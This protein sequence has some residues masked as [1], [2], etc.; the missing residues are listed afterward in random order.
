MSRVGKLP[1]SL[2][3]KVEVTVASDNTVMVKGPKGKI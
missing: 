3:D 2:P 1:I